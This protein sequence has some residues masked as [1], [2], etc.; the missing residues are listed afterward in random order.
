MALAILPLPLPGFLFAHKFDSLSKMPASP[1][2]SSWA[3]AASIRSLPSPCTTAWRRAARAPLTTL[4]IDGAEHNDFYDVGG[5]QID[6][7]IRQFVEG[8][9]D[10]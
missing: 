5:Q 1:A 2:R 4:V 3:T 8:L 6:E 9:R 10:W 7:A